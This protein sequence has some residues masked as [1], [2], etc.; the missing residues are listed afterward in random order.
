VAV[1]SS[2]SSGGLDI[3]GLPTAEAKAKVG[4]VDVFRFK[5]CGVRWCSCDLAVI[6]F[7]GL[8]VQRAVSAR[9]FV[10]AG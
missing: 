5:L 8:G 2:S 9:K 7:S 4:I 10:D 1:A 6:C 3:N